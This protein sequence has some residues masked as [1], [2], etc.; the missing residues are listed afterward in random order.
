MKLGLDP[1]CIEK[2]EYIC[3]LVLIVQ[4]RNEV[5]IPEICTMSR[6]LKAISICWIYCSFCKNASFKNFTQYEEYLS[7]FP[8]LTKWRKWWM[9]TSVG[10]L[11]VRCN[12]NEMRKYMHIVEKFVCGYNWKRLSY[13]QPTCSGSTSMF[14]TDWMLVSAWDYCPYVIKYSPCGRGVMNAL[15]LI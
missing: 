9:L 10:T 15:Q 7:K 13:M 2:A 5:C 1:E 14:R 12:G 8:C 4:N 6:L 11:T 3:S